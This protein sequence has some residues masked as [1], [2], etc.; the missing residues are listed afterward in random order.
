MPP[1]LRLCCCCR[2]ILVHC[3]RNT[4]NVPKH[5]QFEAVRDKPDA[6][7]V[8]FRCENLGIVVH[9]MNSNS[10]TWCSGA[11]CVGRLTGV[12]IVQ[13]ALSRRID[14]KSIDGA[15]TEEFYFETLLLVLWWCLLH[16]TNLLLIAEWCA[17]CVGVNVTGCGVI[18]VLRGH[19][20]ELIT[21]RGSVCSHQAE[22][23]GS[24]AIFRNS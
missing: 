24:F 6:A 5:K 2:N 15:R 9:R 22:S 10:W 11:F 7:S 23:S 13:N 19:E 21:A 3:F 12:S 14:S 8:R 16:V 4:D 18:H 20:W 1:S 17:F